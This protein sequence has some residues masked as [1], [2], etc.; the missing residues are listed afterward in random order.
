MDKEV[1][2]NLISS[3]LHKVQTLF[4]PLRFILGVKYWKNRKKAW[5]QAIQHLNLARVA[6]SCLGIK[7]FSTSLSIW[8]LK[9]KL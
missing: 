7:F 6:Q 9:I 5:N 1:L 8:R 3:F 4:A 2:K